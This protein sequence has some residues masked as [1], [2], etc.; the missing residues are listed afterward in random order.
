VLSNILTQEGYQVRKSLAGQM[1]LTACQT[2]TLN[3]TL[4]DINIPDMNS[5]ECEHLK[6]NDNA[7]RLSADLAV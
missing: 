3:L 6:A 5:Y 4:L 1:A 2:Q 7:V